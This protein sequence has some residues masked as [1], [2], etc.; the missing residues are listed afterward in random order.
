MQLLAVFE[1]DFICS[2]NSTFFDCIYMNKELCRLSE[3]RGNACITT[4]N[5]PTTAELSKIM[6]IWLGETTVTLKARTI[7]YKLMSETAVN[8]TISPSRNP[9]GIGV[10]MMVGLREATAVHE[11]G[12]L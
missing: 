8:V 12:A 4:E 3:I 2:W 10:V 9:C 6:E 1:I 5:Y 7:V 11:I